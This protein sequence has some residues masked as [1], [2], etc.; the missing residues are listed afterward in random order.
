MQTDNSALSQILTSRDMSDLYSRWYWKIAEFP[1]MKL[2]HRAGR[3][4]YCSDALSRHREETDEAGQ[5][6]FVEP[7]ELFRTIGSRT[8]VSKSGR[9]QGPCINDNTGQV[10]VQMVRDE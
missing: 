9:A 3:K 10:Y 5:P 8:T 4:L 7:G 2:S 1:G 6:F